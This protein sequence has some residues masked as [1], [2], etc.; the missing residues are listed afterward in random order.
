MNKLIKGINDL[1]TKC[2]KILKEWNKNKN[3]PIQP[4]EI[5]FGSGKKVW[6][7]CPKGHEYFMSVDKRTKRNQGCPY[8][9]GHKVNE[10]N[11]V[12]NLYPHLVKE[13]DFDK[14]KEKTLHDFTKGSS[15]KA[16]WI[17]PNGHSY[18]MPISNRVH[19][20]KCP[21][22]NGQRTTIDNC[23]A[24]MDPKLS[25]EWNSIKNGNLTP[26]D[27]TPGSHKKV[28]WR[29]KNGH[30]WETSVY[31]RAKTHCGCPICDSE[32]RTSFPEQAILFYLRKIT[33]ALSRYKIGGFEADIFCPEIN[34]AI[35][36]DGEYF[37]KGVKAKIR[38][39]NKNKYFYESK[40][41][42]IRIK[43]TKEKEIFNISQTEYGFL[44]NISYSQDY[45]FV[46]PILTFIV[47]FINEKFGF[48]Y[49]IS[50]QIE[51]DKN[52]IIEQYAIDKDENSFL[53]RK[54]LG[55]KKWDYK[56]N[57]NIKLSLLPMTSKKKYWW[58]CPTCGYEWYGSLD[59]IVD[60]L[61][62]NKCARQVRSDYSVAPETKMDKVCFKI[63]NKNLLTENPQLAAEWHP[64][65][66]GFLRPENV[67]AKSGKR[68]W[69][70]CSKCGYEWIQIIKTRN[71]GVGAR[72]CP[73]CANNQKK[74]K[75]NIA[76]SFNSILIKEFDEEK[77]SPLKLNDLSL[78][79]NKCV[80]W[81]CSKCGTSY[82]CPV[83]TR[84]NN[85]GCPTCANTA[86][87]KS[88]FKKIIN[89]ET[90]DIFDSVLE[91][92]KI[93]NIGRT[94]ISACLQGRSKTAGGYHWKIYEKKV[95]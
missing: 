61:T 26:Y 25:I 78:G 1:E 64:T 87:A 46:E 90:G 10:E 71:N 85:G 73:I 13:W 75:S 32:K 93:M 88:K 65:K 82:F 8:C 52:L 24:T 9:S 47:K 15:Y 2:P 5:H 72:K 4:S 95:K 27:V 83:K 74:R 16:W 86:R 40:V 58:K 43:E 51:E 55:A 23:L 56:K 7:I 29:C 17:C 53:K 21:V 54:P 28:W 49:K 42:L 19:G 44:I 94:S 62:C 60:S 70:K 20:S 67:T 18:D 34:L 92:S 50:F 22:C 31:T 30:E 6:W 37:H 89:I 80:W 41:T 59:G 48:D 91:A 57:G 14:N 76:P 68:V 45:L 38:E 39:D 12:A 33:T 69:W 3:F 35:E 63:L 11:C 36:Y 77:N 79:S 66:N 84:K 81:K